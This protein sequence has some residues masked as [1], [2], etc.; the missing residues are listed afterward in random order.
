[1]SKK[2]LISLLVV[3]IMLIAVPIVLG[4]TD[5]AKLQEITK[6]QQQLL[7]LRKQLVQKYVEDGQI[8]PDQGKAMQDR[9]DQGYKYAE[10][11]GFQ[12]G[13]GCGGGGFGPGMM[14]GGGGRGMMGGWGYG[15][16]GTPNAATQ[17]YGNL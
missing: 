7:D 17:G 12:P 16:G 14:S 8:T 10:E 2:V 3:G 13:P 9:M 1:M 11:N 5:N 6:I 15:P 4:A